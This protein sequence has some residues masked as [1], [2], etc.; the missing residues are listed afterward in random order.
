[1]LEEVL[2][3]Y[4]SGYYGGVI[5]D[6]FFQWEQAGF[7]AYILPFLLIFAVVFGVIDKIQVFGKDKRGVNAIIAV[8]VGLIAVNTEFVPRFFLEIFPQLGV[9]LAIML[10][11]VILFEFFVIK[12]DNKKRGA[13]YIYFGIGTVI[14]LFIIS[15]LA[16]EFGFGYY[17]WNESWA[18][19]IGAVLI[20]AIIAIV[21]GKGD[22][23][24]GTR[25]N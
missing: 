18:L 14:F 13:K 12:E 25:I 17:M 2:Y 20:V 24:G 16:D 22:D 15:N 7:F 4:S 8:V 5:G 19:L 23:S 21:V 9:G 3:M 10:V 1:M 11:A 6:M